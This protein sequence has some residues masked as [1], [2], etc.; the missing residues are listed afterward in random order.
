MDF[1]KVPEYED[2]DNTEKFL[3]SDGFDNPREFYE[4]N[5]FV[6]LKKIF[7]TNNCD[8]LIKFGCRSVPFKG[9]IYRQATG[10]LEKIFLKTKLGDEPILNLQ[11]LNPKYF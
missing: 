1:N 7:S 9:F 11:S 2:E 3:L 10:K 5:G 6:I 8:A 4:E